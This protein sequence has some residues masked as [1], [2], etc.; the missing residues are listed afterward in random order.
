MVAGCKTPP[1]VTPEASWSVEQL[2]AAVAEDARR[3]DHT[4][5]SAVRARL[6]ADAA[7]NAQACLDRAPQSAACLYSD[8]IALGLEAQA[9]PLHASETLKTMLEALG[10]AEAVDP[11]H[12]EAGP[13]RVRALV[14]TRAPGWPLGPG[15]ADLGLAAAR[16]AVSLRPEYPPNVLALAEA[17]EKTGD[18]RGAREA[19]Q[20]AQ[21]SIQAMPPSSDRDDWLRQADQGLGRLPH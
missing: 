17:L 14:L 11:E 12:D 20:R 9:H 10:R 1:P 21:L 2:A 3:N 15:D 7:G 5:D 6:A 18:T 8:A 13:A 16:R 19:Y 4:S